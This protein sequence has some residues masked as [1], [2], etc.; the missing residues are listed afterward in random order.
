M[1]DFRGDIRRA[2]FRKVN[3]SDL[4]I[5]E[6]AMGI[7]QILFEFNR[8]FENF[9][10]LEK[11]NIELTVPIQLPPN[12][13]KGDCKSV[14]TE[15]QKA[16]NELGEGS[17]IYHALGSWLDAELNVVADKCCVIFTAIKIEKWYE[18]IPV[19][20]SLIRDEIQSNLFQKCVF[21]RID[22]ETFGEP[23]NLLGEQIKEFPDISEFG[24]IDPDC[25]TMLHLYNENKIQ[26]VVNQ[27]ISG[28]NSVQINSG[29]DSVIA[30][31][32]GAMAAGGNITIQNNYGVGQNKLITLQEK[33]IKLLEEKIQSLNSEKDEEVQQRVAREVSILAETLQSN[34]ADLPP[35]LLYEAAK[36]SVNA[37][38][39]DVAEGQYKQAARH[40]KRVG[41]KYLAGGCFSGLFHVAMLRGKLDT[42]E[43]FLELS[44]NIAKELGNNH[45]IASSY[46]DKGILAREK[47]LLN[48]AKQFHKNALDI[49]KES[50]DKVVHARALNNL[51]LVLEN[52]GKLEQA[53]EYLWQSLVLKKELN[54]EIGVAA[55]LGNLAGFAS[56]RGD[57][58]EAEELFLHNKRLL[59]KLQDNVNLTLTIYNL[60]YLYER[61]GKYDKAEEYYRKCLGMSEEYGLKDMQTR[62][63]RAV[64]IILQKQREK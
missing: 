16:F 51:S 53:E 12:G 49:S 10:Q 28:D 43:H 24:E 48:Q 25:L 37:G 20:Q 2:I 8:R 18:I 62:S 50:G 6:E 14:V 58:I 15:V 61:M 33:Q 13:K 39:L 17:R 7:S 31:G 38:R 35:D 26:S 54:D 3:D 64:D 5:M 52:M 46:T 41:D 60:G 32:K 9:D 36:S 29:G 56:D 55:V 34:G 19:L 11:I 57:F 40:F 42:A 44:H 21:L 22:N 27:S 59:L 63:I 4:D 47:G 30:H 45:A 1:S 23:V